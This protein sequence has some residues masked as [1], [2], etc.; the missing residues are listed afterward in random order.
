MAD[1]RVCPR[2]GA[3]RQDASR[4]CVSC[5]LDFWQAAA[6]STGGDA[7]AASVANAPAAQAPPV[8]MLAIGAGVILLV[9]AMALWL[10]FNVLQP[11]RRG[12]PQR[13]TEAPATH[14]L[15]LSFFSEA[16]DPEAAFAWTQEGEV[17]VTG[18]SE[19][20]LTSVASEGRMAGADWIA[21]M[22]ITETDQAAFTGEI[23]LVGGYAY[24]RTGDGG[25]TAG[26]RIPAAALDPVNP[27]ARITTV[28][29]LEYVGPVARDG[30]DAHLLRTTKWLSDQGLA[31]AVRRVAHERSR[32]S[33]MEIVVRPDGVPQ[34]AVH[35]FSL[36]ARTPDGQIVT[37]SGRS[38]YTFTDWGAVD[39]VTAPTPNPTASPSGG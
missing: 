19:E 28:A 33:V 20:L 1:G 10:A 37:L 23:A 12:G 3:S 11:D 8:A 32:E 17:R 21:S 4:F 5:G 29:E 25:W 6:G 35:T 16:R 22:T 39:P 13:L 34:S 2:C 30:R 9:G 18:L 15:V 36:E 7:R 24:T 14:P 26:E 31:A 38:T 27:F